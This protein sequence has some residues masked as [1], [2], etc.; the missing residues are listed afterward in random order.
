VSLPPHVLVA[1][2]GDAAVDARSPLGAGEVIEL[3]APTLHHL[4]RTLRLADGAALSVTDGA[5]GHAH[6]LLT[7]AGA[8]LTTAVRREVRGRPTLTL[9]QA[10]SKGRRAEDAVRMACELGVDRVVPLV[11]ERTQGRPDAD[12]RRSLTAR[13]QA[14]ADAAL[15]QSRGLWRTVV[16]VVSDVSEISALS[17]PSDRGR[18]ADVQ[19]EEP[20][21]SGAVLPLLAVP[22]APSL[23]SVL[24][25]RGSG[26]SEVRVAVGPEGGWSDEEVADLTTAGWLPVGLGPEVLRTEHAGPVAL[27]VVAA[28]TGR[29]EPQG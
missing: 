18:T 1:Q 29:W 23:P 19:H 6:A 11:A 12:A 2:L 16:T 17:E 28:S 8:E 14:V 21:C 25:R 10:L 15:E 24:D 13:W 3:D 22:G 4:R 20:T 26:V 5:G 7:A 27:A 9:V